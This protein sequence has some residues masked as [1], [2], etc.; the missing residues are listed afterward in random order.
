M[1]G[2][3]SNLL[4]L[5][6]RT[7]ALAGLGVLI[8]WAAWHEYSQRQQIRSLTSARDQALTRASEAQRVADANRDALAEEQAQAQRAIAAMQ[9]DRDAALDR[10]SRVQTIHERIERVPSTPCP[11]PDRLRV[12]LDGLRGA[13]SAASDGSAP[14]SH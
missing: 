13:A 3:L 12:G 4:P 7:L 1:I 10:Q 5:N 11:L 9:S 8:A 14:D 2:L 6:L